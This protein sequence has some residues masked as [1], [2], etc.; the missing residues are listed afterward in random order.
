MP[1][2]KNFT[3]RKRTF[4]HL[5]GPRWEVDAGLIEGKRRRK[6][7]TTKKAADEYVAEEKVRLRAHG[8][9]S[10][11]L[12]EDDRVLFQAAR[13]RLREAGATINQAVEYYVENHKPLRAAV[14]LAEL[15]TR[16][17]L[18]KELAG[19]RR[20]S[21]QQFKCSCL[22]FVRGREGQL[23][24]TVT[25]DEVK[26]WVHGNAFAPKTQRTY[27]GDVRSLFEWARQERYIRVN[28]R[29]R[30][31]ISI[32][33]GGCSAPRCSR[34]VSSARA[35]GRAD[36]R[37]ARCPAGSVRCSGSSWLRCSAGCGRWRSSAR[38]SAD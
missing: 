10:V 5:T 18:E 30:P 12:S 37:R 4:P 22:S 21:L 9:T 1:R 13:D 27:L 34:R 25:R 19:L 32:T 35:R 7:F 29:S 17:T 2:P 3:V 28:R 38:R 14:T 36:G 20:H 6:F 33:A 31:S 11:S 26:A 8:E 16:A 15:L 23:A 24:H